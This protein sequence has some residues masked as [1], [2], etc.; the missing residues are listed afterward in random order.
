MAFAQLTYRESLRDIVHCLGAQ[1]SKMYHLGFRSPITKSTLSYANNT[2][3]WRIYADLA[4]VLI[5]TAKRA[6]S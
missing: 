1:Q 5:K 4:A 2:R 6:V 3:D